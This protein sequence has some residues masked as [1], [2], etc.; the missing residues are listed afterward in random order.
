MDENDQEADDSP[1]RISVQMDASDVNESE[2]ETMRGDTIGDTMYSAKWI[3]N[4]LIS[5]SNVIKARLYFDSSESVNR[6]N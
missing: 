6:V 2:M 4:V 3:I 5:L 1:G